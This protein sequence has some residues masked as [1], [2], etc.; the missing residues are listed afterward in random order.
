MKKFKVL[1]AVVLAVI[2]LFSFNCNNKVEG[3]SYDGSQVTDVKNVILLIGD[4]MGPN[5]IRAGEI[6]KGEQLFMQKIP[7]NT[8][9]ETRSASSLI[10]DS[11]A[12]ATAMS[13]GVRTIN[14]RVG[15]D[16]NGVELET[17]VDLAKKNGKKTGVITTEELIGATPMAFSGHSINRNNADELITSAATASNVDLFATFTLSQTRYLDFFTNNG[18]EL[19][20]DADK[21]SE[22]TSEKVFGNFQI[23]AKAK[24]MTITEKIVAFD[25]VVCEGL[26]YLSKNKKGFFLMAEGAHIDH[27]GHANDI[28]YMLEELYAFD[29]M[30]KAVINWAEKRTDTVVIVTADHETGG[31]ELLNEEQANKRNF[32]EMNGN[33]NYKYFR[34]TDTGHTHT[35]V[36]LFYYGPKIE[37]ANYSSFD[38]PTEKLIKNIDIFKIMKSYIEPANKN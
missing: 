22:S 33:G 21:L 29:D 16:E 14:G 12:S 8:Y 38:E 26:E 6:F 19:I 20:L 13:T 30:V 35:P 7:Q 27:G 17:I 23:D 2:C 37:F 3:N 25:R 36:R 4:G 10:T 18:Y 28:N 9:V 5:Q 1:T 15:I 24:S 31:L 32:L 11:A 34:W